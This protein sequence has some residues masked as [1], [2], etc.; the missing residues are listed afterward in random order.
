MNGLKLTA[1]FLLLTR[2]LAAESIVIHNQVQSRDHDFRLVQVAGNIPNPWSLA[3]L[4]DGG[5]LVTQRSGKLW[6]FDAEGENR[7]EI[8]G[9]PEVRASGQGRPSGCGASSGL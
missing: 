8:T 4:P 1:V 6:L 3:F 7:L 2:F 5:F 9:L